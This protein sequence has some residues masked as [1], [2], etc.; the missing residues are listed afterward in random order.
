LGLQILTIDYDVSA[1]SADFLCTINNTAVTN[2]VRLN[3]PDVEHTTGANVTMC[4]VDEHYN[5]I[6]DALSDGWVDT[7]ETWAYA[8]ANTITIPAGGAS[9]FEVGDKIKLTQTTVKYF[10]VTGVADTV[11]TV[12]GG[13]DYTLSNATITSPY[14]SRAASPVGFPTWFNQAVVVY[15]FSSDPTGM[16]SQFMIQGK[17]CTVRYS[18]SGSGTSDS[19]SKYVDLPVTVSLAG[20]T[21]MLT[22]VMNNGT[23]AIGKIYIA[24]GNTRARFF[25]TLTGATFTASGNCRLFPDGVQITYPIA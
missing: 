15:G 12:T 8:S 17:S 3:G 24:N 21:T 19:T 2:M 13:S 16:A 18:D 10:Y 25:P 11:L 14:Y 6:F 23:N 5:L 7:K 1:K 20:T 4:A 22:N 9:R